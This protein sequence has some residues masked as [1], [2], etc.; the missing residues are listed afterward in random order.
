[1]L[2]G[3]I[4]IYISGILQITLNIHWSADEKIAQIYVIIIILAIPRVNLNFALKIF[5]N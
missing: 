3:N 5:Q 1:M 2:H 4:Y